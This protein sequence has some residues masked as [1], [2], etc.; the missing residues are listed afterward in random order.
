MTTLRNK[1]Y[2]G[3]YDP[4][5]AAG[6]E[7]GSEPVKYDAPTFHKQEAVKL[8]YEYPWPF[9]EKVS[10]KPLKDPAEYVGAK[11]PQDAYIKSIIMKSELQRQR[12]AAE[13][14]VYPIKQQEKLEDLMYQYFKNEWIKQTKNQEIQYEASLRTGDDRKAYLQQQ[15]ELARMRGDMS[16]NNP[17][18]RQELYR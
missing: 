4:W 3:D 11:K 16:I 17:V 1:H 13:E 18:V 10:K 5:L 12:R 2:T 6:L 15:Y 7:Y 8:N 14:K 9:T